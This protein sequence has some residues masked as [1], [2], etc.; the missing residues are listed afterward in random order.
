MIAVYHGCSLA[1][2]P[3]AS[4]SGQETPQANVAR[5]VSCLH[6]MPEHGLG[7][8]QR[9]QVWLTTVCPDG[10]GNK[11]PVPFRGQRADVSKVSRCQAVQWFYFTT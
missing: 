7:G 6:F 11:D 2:K 3:L 8:F 5:G 1:G 10:F 4:R 9:I